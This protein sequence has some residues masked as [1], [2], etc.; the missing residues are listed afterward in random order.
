MSAD[1]SG[2][3]GLFMGGIVGG[4]GWSPDAKRIVFLSSTTATTV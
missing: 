4:V 3:R 1:G 2:P